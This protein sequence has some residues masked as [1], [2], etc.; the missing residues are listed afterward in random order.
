LGNTYY[1][2]ILSEKRAKSV[3][4]YLIQSGINKKRIESFGYGSSQPLSNSRTDEI[5]KKNRRV[6]FKITKYN[7]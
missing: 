3:A 7:N 6:E 4:D 2:K 1:N 5:R